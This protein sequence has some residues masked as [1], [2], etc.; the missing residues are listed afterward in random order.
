VASRVWWFWHRVDGGLGFGVGGVMA[1]DGDAGRGWVVWE[2]HEHKI[3][4]SDC[5][6]VENSNS[7]NGGGRL[8]LKV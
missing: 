1:D 5:Q 6:D 3:K 7:I 4:S 8:Q 2:N